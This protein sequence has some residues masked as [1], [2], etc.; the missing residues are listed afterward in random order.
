MK[1][2]KIFLLFL[3]TVLLCLL[4]C[5]KPEKQMLV[6]TGTVTNILTTTA[7]VSGKILDL[8]EGAT[9]FG[10][11]YSKTTNPTTS[12]LKTVYSSPSMG[13]FTSSLESL[14]PATKYYV[15]AYL[16][17]GQDVV[18]GDEINFTTASSALPELTTTITSTITKTSAVSGGNITNQGGTPVTARGVCWSLATGPTADLTTKTV[19]GSGTG[20]FTSNLTGLANG[21]VYYVRAYATNSAG[22]A[23]GNEISFMTYDIVPILTTEPV[24]SITATSAVGNGNIL[25]NGDASVTARGMCWS[26]SHNPSLADSWSVNG[27]GTG[28]FTSSITSLN[29]G[30]LYYVRAYATNSF[31]TGYGNEV[32]FTTLSPPNAA[33]TL[34]SLI[35]TVRANLNG[36]VN[37]KNNSTVVTFEYG[38]TMGYGSLKTADQSPVTGNSDTP[39]SATLTGL[40]PGTTYHY[41]IKAVSSQGTTYGDDVQFSTV[42]AT[43]TDIDGNIY[44]TVSINTQIWLLENLKV[45][46]FNNNESAGYFSY[47]NVVLQPIISAFQTLIEAG[48]GGLTLSQAQSSG[49]ISALQKTQLEDAAIAIGISNVTSKTI[50]QLHDEVFSISNNTISYGFLYD[51]VVVTDTRKLC[52]VGWHVPSDAEWTVLTDYLGGMVVAGGK[53]KETGTTHWQTPNTGAT[54]EYGFTALPAGEIPNGGSFINIGIDGFWWSAASFSTDNAWIR[55]LNYNSGEVSRTNESKA[56]LLSVRCLKD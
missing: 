52:P 7:D 6:S 26:T 44:H 25:H 50:Q 20:V 29:P 27:S 51:W 34:P 9:Q 5:K 24:S 38:L 19:N 2:R 11:C 31:G 12:G 21:T 47:N 4:T 43:I 53:L 8:G 45:T 23:Y 33:T 39:V 14:E 15:K 10:H 13:G 1:T 42:P 17:K 55:S 32:T 49:Y 48:I 40:T 35:T 3:I 22:T 16:S 30:T 46:H 37:A 54:N 18:Y 28:P 36:I 56:N 41:R